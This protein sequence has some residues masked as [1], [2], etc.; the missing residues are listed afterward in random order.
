MTM[1]EL[2]WFLFLIVFFAYSSY[3]IYM[4]WKKDKYKGLNIRY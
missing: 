4:Q 1:E 3:I 2:F